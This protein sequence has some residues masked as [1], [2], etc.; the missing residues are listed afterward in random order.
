M[1]TCKINYKDF[2]TTAYMRKETEP[3]V[4]VKVERETQ[5]LVSKGHLSHMRLKTVEVKN[6]LH[7]MK[8]GIS[9]SSF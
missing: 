8:K 3:G 6:S 9:K 7:L 1:K 2:Q 4:K 5:K